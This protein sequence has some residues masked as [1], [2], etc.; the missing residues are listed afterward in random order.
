MDRCWCGN[1]SLELW[2]A[3]YGKCPECATLVDLSPYLAE[4]S[5]ADEEGSLYNSDYWLK[6]MAGLYESAGCY[7][8][9]DIILYHYRERAAYWLQFF[10]RHQLPPARVVEVGCGMGSFTHW[11][12]RLGYDA[13]ATELSGSWRAIVTDMLGIAISDELLTTEAARS[14][15]LDAIIMLDVLEHIPDPMA[16]FAAVSNELKDSGI[17]MIQMPE[18][19]GN[20]SHKKMVK[21]KDPFLRYLLP[22]EHLFLYS[23]LGLERLLDQF[24]FVYRTYYKSIFENDVF[25]FAS[26]SPLAMHE[27]A[28]ITRAFMKPGSIAPYAA[29]KNY[30][31]MEEWKARVQRTPFNIVKRMIKKICC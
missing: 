2:G 23:R 3:G 28:A 22:Q 6:K 29:L 19:T 21:K 17:I 24:G 27:D 10:V 7:T 9:E 8:F 16:L 5:S 30:Q 12:S 13:S 26:R 11:L 20:V 15:R 31:L 4:A 18:Y 14:N 1:A 25:F